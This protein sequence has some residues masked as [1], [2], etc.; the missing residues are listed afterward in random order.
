MDDVETIFNRNP[1]NIGLSDKEAYGV[2]ISGHGVNFTS[3]FDYEYVLEKKEFDQMVWY[4]LNNC[5]QAKKY[6]EYV[7][8]TYDAF[9]LYLCDLLTNMFYP[10]LQNV[11]R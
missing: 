9:V 4:V 1:R 7:E 5:D 6:I 2:D 10:I 3:G 8:L 11:Q